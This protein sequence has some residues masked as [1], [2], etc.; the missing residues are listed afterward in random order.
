MLIHLPDEYLLTKPIMSYV[1]MSVQL[2]AARQCVD[3]TMHVCVPHVTIG[4]NQI[5]TQLSSP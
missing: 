4:E 5:A 2:L 3:R 1:S